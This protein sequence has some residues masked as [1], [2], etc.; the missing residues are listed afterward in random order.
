MSPEELEARR[1]A[2][3]CAAFGTAFALRMELHG[4]PRM[5]VVGSELVEA[6]IDARP[7]A[8]RWARMVADA[9]VERSE[10]AER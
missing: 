10:H 9:A 3:W 1:R 7:E 8:D 2:V 5:Q 4:T 6:P